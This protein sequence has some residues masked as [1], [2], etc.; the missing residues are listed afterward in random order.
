MRAPKTPERFVYIAT[1]IAVGHDYRRRLER[2]RRLRDR[3]ESETGEAVAS[4]HG[5]CH[6][7]PEHLPTTED[8]RMVGRRMVEG[9]SEC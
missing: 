6:G 4:P 9:A 3:I 1:T 5:K 2:L 7:E 8:L